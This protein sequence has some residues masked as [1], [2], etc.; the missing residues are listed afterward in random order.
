M[1]LKSIEYAFMFSITVFI[2]ACEYKPMDVY[3][4]PVTKD[5]LPPQIETL[6][7]DIKYD[8]IFL[9]PEK[10]INFR[11]SSSNQEIKI[12]RFVIDN[13]PDFTVNSN[14]GTFDLT[15]GTLSDGVHKL[16]LE[17]YT[18]SGT[19]SIAEL[20]GAEAFLFTKSWTIIVDRSYSSRTRASASNGY[21]KL[22]WPKYRDYDFQ[23]YIISRELSYNNEVVIKRL[24]TTEFIDSSYVG[25]GAS[26]IVRVDNQKEK[27]LDWGHVELSRE[28]P[29]MKLM[30]TESDPFILKWGKSKYY[31]AVDTIKLVQSLN[32][33]YNYKTVKTTQDPDDSIYVEETGLFADNVEFILRL[34]PKNRN[35]RYT[36]DFYSSFESHAYLILGYPFIR[37]NTSI[38]K[39]NQVNQDEFVYREACDSIIR[40]SISEKHS[41]EQLGYRSSGCSKCE[42]NTITLSA[43][44]KYLTNYANCDNDLMLVTTNN[45]NNYIIRDLKPY[46]GLN[47][48]PVIFVSDAGTALVNKGNGGFSIYDFNTDTSLATY[49]K[50][51]NGGEGL[52]MSSQG[53][54][55]FLDDDSLRLVGF[56]NS[57]FT[58][59]WSW[60]RYAYPKY[61]GF[62]GTNP[63]QVCIWDGVTFSVKLCS[64]FSDVY[65]FS[66]SD[67]SLLD[68]DFYNNEILTYNAGHLY[69]KSYLDGSLIK[70]LP[71]HLNPTLNYYTFSLINHAIVSSQGVIYF[72]K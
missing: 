57:Q 13:E 4:R 62:D 27:L 28:L 67:N 20:I 68:I 47:Y 21:L 14:N 44:G 33:T 46:S 23:E 34:V 18:A 40:Y 36:S 53:D 54:F 9:Y 17:V 29:E 22:T 19:N 52:L 7:L 1:K 51:F 70:D 31:N 12:V 64:D 58:N 8:T 41:T 56:A 42:F 45:M 38:S 65:K 10:I 43:S 2:Q 50:T 26:Y 48:T 6:V 24:K 63:G 35:I 66:L 3:D 11:F 69:V 72:I 71:I 49:Q 15:F 5:V 32:T 30:P 25:E 55:L 39:I 60:D 59:V 37:P 16:V 61:F